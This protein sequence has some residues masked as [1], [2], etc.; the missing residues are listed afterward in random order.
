M[1]KKIILI[2]AKTMGHTMIVLKIN[3]SIAHY[4]EICDLHM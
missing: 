4:S 1:L 3:K 2:P